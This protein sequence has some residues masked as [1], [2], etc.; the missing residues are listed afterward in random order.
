M[1]VFEGVESPQESKERSFL[2]LFTSSIRFSLRWPRL[3]RPLFLRLTTRGA[4]LEKKELLLGGPHSD[5]PVYQE[6]LAS[7]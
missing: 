7:F 1:I 3:W 5:N 6:L 4:R 2:P